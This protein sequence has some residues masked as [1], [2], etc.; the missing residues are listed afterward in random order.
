MIWGC[1]EK[2]RWQ[3][4]FV[5]VFSAIPRML[6]VN[7][8]AVFIRPLC[9]LCLVSAFSPSRTCHYKRL[10]LYY[11]EF[12][13][14]SLSKQHEPLH[15]HQANECTTFPPDTPSKDGIPNAP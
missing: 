5:F 6:L 12:I 8:A 10:E 11:L 7:R 9:I 14:F 15:I 3:Y 1:E 4:K 2:C 13:E